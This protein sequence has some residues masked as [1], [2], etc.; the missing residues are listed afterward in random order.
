MKFTG[1]DA[2]VTAMSDLSSK[3][4]KDAK[5]NPP[6]GYRLADFFRSSHDKSWTQALKISSIYFLIGSLWIIMSDKIAAY[7]F[8]D[9]DDLV[10]VNI[11]KGWLYVLT[12]AVI[13]YMLIHKELQRVVTSKMEVTKINRELEKSN[14][15]FS[16]ILESSPEIMVYSIDRSYCYTA[17]NNRHKY[18]MLRKWNREIY[19]A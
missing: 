14:T 7:L 8:P 5:T 15:L 6:K 10:T 12:T 16:A 3:Q 1:S 4:T 2:G 18:S 17:F 13:L 19:T 11:T 9:P